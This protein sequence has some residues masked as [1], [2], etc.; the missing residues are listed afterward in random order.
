CRED[1]RRCD[2]SATGDLSLQL[3]SDEVFDNATFIVS[4]CPVIADYGRDRVIGVASHPHVGIFG[5][6]PY[7]HM[8]DMSDVSDD[9]AKP[10][11]HIALLLRRQVEKFWPSSG[12][13]WSVRLDTCC[14]ATGEGGVADMTSGKQIVGHAVPSVKPRPKLTARHSE[15]SE[16]LLE[17]GGRAELQAPQV[18]MYRARGPPHAGGNLSHRHAHLLFTCGA[19]A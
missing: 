8:T 12:N 9:Y 11:G 19:T 5:V 6:D 1:C 3:I 13:Q 2:W 10:T 17:C 16:K 18:R 4:L 15:C 14:R 7:I